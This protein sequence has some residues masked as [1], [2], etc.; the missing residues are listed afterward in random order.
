MQDHGKITLNEQQ[1][2]P[3]WY[4]SSMCKGV[5]IMIYKLW[6]KTGEVEGNKPKYQGEG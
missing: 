1:S 4:D 2:G 3:F 5:K 6:K